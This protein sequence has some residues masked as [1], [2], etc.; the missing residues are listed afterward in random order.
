MLDGRVLAESAAGPRAEIGDEIERPDDLAL[1]PDGALY[2]SNGVAILR[3]AATTST[4]RT[5]FARLA[6]PV[7]GIAW[8]ADGR[9]IACVSRHGL[10][11]L[12]SEGDA[13]GNETVAATDRLSALGDGRHGRDHLS[14]RRA[15][16]RT[17][18]KLA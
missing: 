17:R 9:L 8:T 15:R 18:P 13:V 7:G 4:Q 1:G 14:N 5:V 12:S 16:A 3:C 11:A 6:S 2:V 10:V